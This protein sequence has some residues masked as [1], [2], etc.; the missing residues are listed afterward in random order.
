MTRAMCL[1]RLFG[2]AILAGC[3]IGMAFL[4]C[5]DARADGGGPVTH[6]RLAVHLVPAENRLIGTDT[7]MLQA[8]SQWP[9]VLLLSPRASVTGVRVNGRRVEYA[10][11]G[12]RLEIA[13]AEPEKTGDVRVTVQYQGV[14]DDPAPVM[15]VNTDNP[16][17]GVTGTIG[18]SGTFLLA[19]AGWYPGLAGGLATFDLTVTAP[20]G[21]VAVSAGSAGRQETANGKTV[22]TWSVERPVDGLS[23]SAAR[24]VV[25][26]K[27]NGRVTAMTFMLPQTDPLADSYL[28][29]IL[30]YISQYEALFGR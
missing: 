22:S 30:R 26:Q 17:Y 5:P 23:L 13:A 19:G 27:T 12:G 28:D 15:P 14:F 21:V 24:Y 25:R 18:E 2:A 10:F 29:A 1:K 4:T 8:D 7:L 16:G 11:G 3:L 20:E 6:H 9:P